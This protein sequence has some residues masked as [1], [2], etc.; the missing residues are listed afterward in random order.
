MKICLIHK[1]CDKSKGLHATIAI[2]F[3]ETQNQRQTLQMVHYSY[4][5]I[6]AA[7]RGQ[8]REKGSRFLAFAYPVSDENAI[9][10]RVAHLEKKYFDARHHCFAWMLGAE[11][12]SFRAFDG[13]EP[14]HSAGE[15]ILG[16]IRSRDLTDVLVVVVRYFGGVKLG[17]GGLMNAYKTAAAD[18]LAHAAIVQKDVMAEVEIAYAYEATPDVMRVVREFDLDIQAQD[19]KSECM[20]KAEYKLKDKKT[21]LERLAL[22]KAMGVKIKYQ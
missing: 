6:T 10:E 15:P 19:F 16:Q 3:F 8:Y 22:M 9:K 12:K 21:F 14:N 17:V 11:R 18:A 5:T 4:R 7:A 20:L 2:L 1:D 13:G